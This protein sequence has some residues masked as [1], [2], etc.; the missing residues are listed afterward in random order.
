MPITKT[1]AR[2]I[3]I[4]VGAKRVSDGA[5][6]A[7]ADELNRFA[8]SL[9]KKAVRL[10]KHAKRKTIMKEDVELAK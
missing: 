7:L 4:D 1:L 3:L 9:A 8:Y 5:S 6:E 10:A 2:R